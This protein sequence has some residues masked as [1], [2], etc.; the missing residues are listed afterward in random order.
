MASNCNLKYFQLWLLVLVSTGMGTFSSSESAAPI[1]I[2]GEIGGNVTFPCS[3][4]NQRTVRLFYF[5]RGSTFVNGYHA[6]KDMPH[7]T[8]PWENTEVNRSENMV[9]MYRLNTSHSGDYQ[10][11][12]QYSDTKN[13]VTIDI[14]LSVTANYSKPTVITSCEDGGLS[15]LVTCASHGGYPQTKMKFDVN[16][17]RNS[18]SR[19]WRVL[20][21][22]EV[23]DPANKMFN[24]S[25]T[26]QF[27]CSN[28]ELKF[29]SCSVGEIISDTFSVCN[30]VHNTVTPY[31]PYVIVAVVVCLMVGVLIVMGVWLRHKYK[32]RQ[33]GAVEGRVNTCTEEVTFLNELT[34][35]ETS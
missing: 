31:S 8:K 20:N 24:S 30:H 33:T 11:H 26:A 12:I 34:R 5:Q 22:S 35:K 7:D 32:K 25:S 4:D 18:S 28:G 19:M 13:T 27:N 23:P 6:F 17:N 2:H 15:C 21:N 10:C 9:H 16:V 14:R 1:Q 29:L 3:V